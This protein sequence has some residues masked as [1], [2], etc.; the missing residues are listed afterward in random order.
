MNLFSSAPSIVIKTPV[1]KWKRAKSWGDYHMALALKS[2]LEG[3]GFRV[4]IQ[5]EPEWYS[6]KGDSYDAV[7]VF[8]GLH[9]YKPKSYQV[10]ILWNISHPDQVSLEEYESYDHVFV[11]S[12]F[13]AE[14]IASQ[15]SKPVKAML[16]CTDPKKFYPPDSYEITRY[17][18]QLLF[19]GNSRD[20]YR[21]V[22][23]DLLPTKYDLSV[24]GKNWSGLIPE[25]YIKESLIRNNL[26]YRYYGS[27]DILLNDHWDD[28]R[29]KGFISNRVFDGLA[30]GAFIISDNVY[31]IE[32]EFGES[33]QVYNSKSELH[34]FLDYYIENQAEAKQKVL[35]G[36]RRVR[37]AHTFDIR[38]EQ[39]A[40]VVLK[41]LPLK[42]K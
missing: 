1:S 20:T 24:Y 4:L 40:K 3:L 10:N 29:G 25:K 27:A 5:I 28:M 6:R 36:M 33:V 22:L 41:L 34:D 32:A 14:H 23:K 11:A 21:K 13:W 26:L 37:E 2:S 38:A 19:V 15:I 7:I 16:Q 17:R 9:R 8:R 12:R 39:F 30:C 18:H 42:N 35:K 31:G